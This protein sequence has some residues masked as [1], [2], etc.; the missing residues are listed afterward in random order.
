MKNDN[1]GLRELFNDELH[2]IFNAENQILDSL[3]KLITL[4]SLPDLKE[5]LKNHLQET[6]NQ[7]SRLNRIFKTLAMT[8]KEK[9]CEAMEGLLTEAEELTGNKARSAALDAA[10]IIAAQ[11][12]EHYEMASYGSLRSFAKQLGLDGSVAELLQETLDE[13]GAADKKLTKIAE[14]S[15]FSSGVNKNATKVAE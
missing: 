5:A 12:V 10:I 11:K 14:G 15:F 3:P 2:D 1:N 4:A 8:P 9:T 13:E 7:V 6:K